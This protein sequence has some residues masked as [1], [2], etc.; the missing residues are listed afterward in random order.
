VALSRNTYRES[1]QAERGIAR[2]PDGDRKLPPIITRKPLR[3]DEHPISKSRLEGYLSGTRTEYIY[4]LKRIELRARAKSSIG[5]PF[6]SYFIWERIIV[7]YSLPPVWELSR[8]SKG[9]EGLLSSYGARVE[10][11][12]HVLV[13]WPSELHL[14]LWFW[15]QVVMH[16]LGHHFIEQYRSKNGLVRSLKAHERLADLHVGR[17]LNRRYQ[18]WKQGQTKNPAQLIDST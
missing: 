15:D 10:Q 7:L 9:W 5:E 6:G 16:E 18:R 12:S 14:E 13:S 3:G 8:L 2:T 1:D 4:G 11:G 17:Y